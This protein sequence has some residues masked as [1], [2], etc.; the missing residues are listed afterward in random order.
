MPHNGSIAAH[1]GKAFFSGRRGLPLDERD[2]MDFVE[3]RAVDRVLLEMA[4]VVNFFENSAGGPKGELDRYRLRPLGRGLYVLEKFRNPSVSS[5]GS[6]K[7][8]PRSYPSPIR[9]GPNFRPHNILA[10]LTLL[11]SRGKSPSTNSRSNR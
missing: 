10:Q 8:V 3:A 1:Q 9:S 4:E 6:V 11:T 5:A 7:T 2:H